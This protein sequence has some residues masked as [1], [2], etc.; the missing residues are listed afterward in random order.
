MINDVGGMLPLGIQ[1][2]VHYWQYLLEQLFARDYFLTIHQGNPTSFPS[3]D[4][5][6]RMETNEAIG[7]RTAVQ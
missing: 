7:W 4:G 3:S 5:N 6:K 2:A 1:L